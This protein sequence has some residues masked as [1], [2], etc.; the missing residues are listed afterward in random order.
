MDG[1][2]C[3]QRFTP[4][5]NLQG[6]LLTARNNNVGRPPSTA[7][8]VGDS[9]LN[10]GSISLSRLSELERAGHQYAY[11]PDAQKVARPFG[12]EPT[13]GIYYIIASLAASALL[14]S[15]DMLEVS[16]NRHPLAVKYAAKLKGLSEPTSLT[17]SWLA[18][19]DDELEAAMTGSGEDVPYREMALYYGLGPAWLRAFSSPM[20]KKS[21][22]RDLALGQRES[23]VASEG[24]KDLCEGI[25]F[26][27]RQASFLALRL[28]VGPYLR[29]SAA[30]RLL[31]HFDADEVAQFYK[32]LT[33]VFSVKL[34]PDFADAA[35]FFMPTTVDMPLKSRD[36][37]PLHEGFH[38]L[39]V[40][41]S[42]ASSI[43]GAD[44]RLKAAVPGYLHKGDPAVSGLFSNLAGKI[45]VRARFNDLRAAAR[46][47][48]SYLAFLQRKGMKQQVYED[49]WGCVH[50]P[51]PPTLMMDPNKWRLTLVDGMFASAGA[52][53]RL[54]DLVTQ[55]TAQYVH[56]DSYA[57]VEHWKPWK[58]WE[59]TIVMTGAEAAAGGKGTP[60]GTSTL[61]AVR[62][63]FPT[64]NRKVAPRAFDGRS[65]ILKEHSLGDTDSTAVRLTAEALSLYM[66]RELSEITAMINRRDEEIVHL[67]TPKKSGNKF[68]AEEGIQSTRTMYTEHVLVELPRTMVPTW[69][70]TTQWDRIQ[71]L[72]MTGG[73]F[74]RT[75]RDEATPVDLTSQIEAETDERHMR[76]IAPVVPLEKAP[77]PSDKR[78]HILT[79]TR[80]LAETGGQIDVTEAGV[81]RDVPIP[82]QKAG[83][84]GLGPQNRVIGT[85]G[86]DAG[87]NQKPEKNA[88]EQK[89]PQGQNTTQQAT[90]QS[91]GEGDSQSQE[92]AGPRKPKGRLLS[93]G[94]ALRLA[95]SRARATD[96]AAK[97]G[98]KPKA[99]EGQAAGPPAGK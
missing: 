89:Q 49:A 78:A 43:V 47:A 24:I 83:G 84:G 94:E 1:I 10:V 91:R 75:L 15:E 53:R 3:G 88:P 44:P 96:D 18:F 20:L 99:E 76:L 65:I 82:T 41:E 48:N 13:A 4:Y 72:W 16:F 61:V 69:F 29:P 56:R 42:S 21:G 63:A 8:L 46:S 67:L 33:A 52:G 7:L 87:A 36:V 90:N 11:T 73:R 6:T 68:A 62:P 66:G 40:I 27:F 50:A 81:Q 23:R 39:G 19:D 38:D 92:Q 60:Y 22:N 70:A 86:G 25:R 95:V 34:I 45:A 37:L 77:T 59:K 71:T 79:S 9:P 57:N 2:I 14:S 30:A 32:D 55:P 12:I 35:A 54:L 31:S 58:G 93:R 97:D 98:Q 17:T 64:K 28:A 80:T 74:M 51:K 85:S 5:L 26:L